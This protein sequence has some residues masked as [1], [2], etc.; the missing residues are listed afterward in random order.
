MKQSQW[1]KID[2]T[3]LSLDYKSSFPSYRYKLRLKIFLFLKVEH[4][5]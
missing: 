2:Y 3:T 4:I 5:R 1:L